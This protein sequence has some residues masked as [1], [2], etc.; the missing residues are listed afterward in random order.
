ML[1]IACPMRTKFNFREFLA[2]SLL[3][4]IDQL[5]FVTMILFAN[6]IKL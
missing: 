6:M 3:N 1:T 4:L 5:Y 2:A